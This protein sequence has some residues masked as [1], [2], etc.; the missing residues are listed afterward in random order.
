MV[1]EFA[2]LMGEVFVM[3]TVPVLASKPVVGSVMLPF[4]K[5]MSLIRVEEDPVTVNVAE[6]VPV[7]PSGVVTLTL[8]VVAPVGTF[9]VILVSLFTVK[10]EVLVVLKVTKFAP[11]KLLPVIVT[12][13]PTAPCVGLKLL[14]TGGSGAD[15]VTVNG[16]VAVPAGVVTV[17][18]PVLAPLGTVVEISVS[19]TTVKVAVLLLLNFTEVA[20]V[21]LLP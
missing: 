8:P 2:P 13:V 12:A 16:A 15:V 7:P 1:M 14:T 10:V 6:L 9:T 11:V 20:P 5:V 17:T 18:L 4:S 3:F 19:E 21:R